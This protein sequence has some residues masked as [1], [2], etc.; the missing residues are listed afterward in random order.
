MTSISLNAIFPSSTISSP[1]THQVRDAVRQEVSTTSSSDDAVVMQIAQQL[2]SHSLS[3]D[4][5]QAPDADG[6]FVAAMAEVLAA[7]TSLAQ[8][9]E[10]F[11]PTPTIA[12]S[13]GAEPQE[14]SAQTSSSL[15]GTLNALSFKIPSEGA[16]SRLMEMFKIG[17]SLAHVDVASFMELLLSTIAESKPST[18]YGNL[19][20]EAAR[21]A[22]LTQESPAPAL[23]S[24]IAVSLTQ[25]TNAYTSAL[26]D[27]PN[28]LDFKVAA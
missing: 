27:V 17:S 11:L 20:A 5:T 24:S 1:S 12:P 23:L 25:V 10:K 7:A 3:L 4:S 8:Q 28:A 19:L 16:T 2:S 14:D 13:V 22:P 6:E 18:S 9:F 26:Q 15:A 21:S